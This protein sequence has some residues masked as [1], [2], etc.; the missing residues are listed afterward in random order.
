MAYKQEQGRMARMAAF[1]T[2]AV[3]IFYGC[4]TLRAELAGR[5]T[6]KDSLGV[7]LWE[8]ARIPVV[9]VEITGAFLIAF[10]VFVGAMILLY[11]WA[12]SPKIADALIDTES[13]L[14]KVTWPSLDEAMQSS[15]VVIVTVLVLM[16]ILA[17]ADALL[18]YYAR[19]ILTGGTA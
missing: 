18:G 8:G 17:G 13:E 9:G 19:L 15:M 16:G 4:V 12:E 2:L 1:W 3:L 14:R 5:A 7:M 6:F 10:V 11:R